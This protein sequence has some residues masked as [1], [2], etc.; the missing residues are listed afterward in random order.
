MSKAVCLLSVF[1]WILI[2]NLFLTFLL[3]PDLPSHP[4]SP[5]FWCGLLGLKI[6]PARSM[7]F[8]SCS[9]PEAP[10]TS[11]SHFVY[12]FFVILNVNA[13]LASVSSLLF[14]LYENNFICSLLFC[15]CPLVRFYSLLTEHPC[16]SRLSVLIAQAICT[17]LK[18]IPAVSMSAVLAGSFLLP[19]RLLSEVFLLFL[20]SALL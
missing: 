7:K 4:S 15:S 11:G 13:R 6:S 12:Q 16:V 9:L 2:G 19:S 5:F 20:L 18:I 1:P 10:W 8:L 14:H 3:Y 17:H